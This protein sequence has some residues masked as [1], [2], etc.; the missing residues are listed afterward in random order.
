MLGQLAISVTLTMT[1]SNKVVEQQKLP[2]YLWEY[3]CVQYLKNNLRIYYL[4]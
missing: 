2:H 3:E 1:S 4:Q